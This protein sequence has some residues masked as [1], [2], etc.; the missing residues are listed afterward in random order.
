M[1]RSFAALLASCMLVASATAIADIPR[2]MNFQGQLTDSGG[3]PVDATLP[4]TFRLYTTDSGGMAV[5]SETKP[6]VVVAHGIFTVLLGSPTPIPLPF[7]VQY[8]ISIQVGDDDEMAP[9]QP[10]AANPYAHRAARADAVALASCPAGMTKV[11]MPGST[12]CFAAG[13]T[14]NW[15]AADQSCYDNFRSSLCTLAQWRTAVCRAGLPSPG[16]SW[17]STPAGT[18]T[19]TTVAGCTGDAVGIAQ[20]TAQHATVCCLEWMSY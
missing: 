9:R 18:A 4:M 3:S 19:F 6:A 11:S 15:E 8:W 10:L 14:Q 13:A 12:L 2:T 16:A 7:D 5:W 20:Y 1:K 17:T